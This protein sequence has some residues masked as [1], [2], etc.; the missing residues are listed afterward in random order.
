[1]RVIALD[2]SRYQ[3]LTSKKYFRHPTGWRDFDAKQ[4]IYDTEI[5]WS[6]GIVNSS[7][8]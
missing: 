6:V 5:V 7:L 1:M 4:A 8:E 2:R 3:W